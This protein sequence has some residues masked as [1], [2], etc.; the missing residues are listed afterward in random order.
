M[1]TKM[2][3]EN[4]DLRVGWDE[5]LRVVRVAA[6]DRGTPTQYERWVIN[7]LTI[8]DVRKLHTGFA[9][10]LRDLEDMEEQVMVFV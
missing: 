1:F 7:E 4:A 8:H 2:I 10:I 6:R 5:Y 3:F 9:D